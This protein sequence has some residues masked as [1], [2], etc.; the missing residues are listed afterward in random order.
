MHRMTPLRRE[1]RRLA[2]PSLCLALCLALGQGCDRS[3]PL[4]PEDAAAPASS[5]ALPFHPDTERAASSEP[6]G[7]AVPGN[8]KSTGGVPVPFRATQTRV[9]PAGTLL[10]VQL[11]GSL[12]TDK[13]RAGDR[14]TASLAAPLTIDGETLI[15]SGTAVTGRVESEQAHAGLPG[16]IPGSG[17]F[18]LTLS[19]I[20]IDGKPIEL[21]TSSLFAR[22][23]IQPSSISS[24]RGPSD[25]QAENVRVRKG[26]PLTFRLTAPVT[27][28]YANATAKDQYPAQR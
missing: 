15:Q 18:Q 3:E 26:H 12:S 2:F 13:V 28:G 9:V 24:S 8:A 5:K 7:P 23:T 11:Q 6:A 22:G 10:T 4:H 16:L 20:S 17:Y 25:S 27:L 14:F 19:T 21:Q 1:A